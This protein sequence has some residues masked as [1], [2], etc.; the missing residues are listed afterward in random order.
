MSVDAIRR[1]WHRVQSIVARARLPLVDDAGPIQ[2]VQTRII[3]DEVKDKV[4]RMAEYG[5]SSNPPTGSD[6]IVLFLAGERSSGVVIATGN[7]RYRFKGL[8]SG[9][10][11]VHDDRGRHVLF[12]ADGIIVEGNT[13]PIR[14]QT[15]SD[16]IATSGGNITLQAS[17]KI[18]LQAPTV[19][20]D[21][22]ALNINATTNQVGDMHTTGA[23]TNDGH[24][25]GFAHEHAPGTF[26][27]GSTFVT[28]ISGGVTP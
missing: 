9:D 28:G 21:A 1:L 26:K 5:F 2:L 12:S 23:L 22:T 10:V 19:E 7:Q 24:D 8:A 11:V 13:D 3:G 16:I 25:V 17:G 6:A 20:I 14:V 18:K 15:E 4:P 27:V